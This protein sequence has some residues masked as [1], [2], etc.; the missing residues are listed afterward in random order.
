MTDKVDLIYDLLKEHK[1]DTAEFQKQVR[2]D[3]KELKETSEKHKEE[4]KSWQDD[5]SNRL[6][7]IEK[8]LREH[9][10]GVINN[11]KLLQIQDERLQLL[12]EPKKVFNTLKKWFVGLGA[13]AGAAVA[14]AKFFGLF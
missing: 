12:E 7:A 8:D 11:R 14:I 13:I 1:S 2:E 10:E 3:Q 9:K 6:D 4:T 5:T